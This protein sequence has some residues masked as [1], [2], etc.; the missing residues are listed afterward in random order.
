MIF[1]SKNG[2]LFDINLQTKDAG[3]KSGQSL[4]TDLYTLLKSFSIENF[5]IYHYFIHIHSEVY[6]ESNAK[7]CKCLRLSGPS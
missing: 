5:Y 3:N 6:T 4:L 7:S 1:H 2:R